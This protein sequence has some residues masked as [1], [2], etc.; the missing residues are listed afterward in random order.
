[1]IELSLSHVT[2]LRKFKIGNEVK[3]VYISKIVCLILAPLINIL[4]IKQKTVSVKI[5]RGPSFTCIQK[6]CCTLTGFPYDSEVN[7]HTNLKLYF[8]FFCRML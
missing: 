5:S 8:V 6:Q 7:V 4:S 3:D 2:R 1:M